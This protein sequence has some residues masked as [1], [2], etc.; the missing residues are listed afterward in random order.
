RAPAALLAEPVRVA[1]AA[2]GAY[3]WTLA[4]PY[5]VR[6]LWSYSG[7]SV[8]PGAMAPI[9][10]RTGWLVLAVAAATAVRVALSRLATH[11]GRL[12]G[13]DLPVPQPRDER[14][15]FA[16]RL[17][18]VPLAALGL[19]LLL[20][21]LLSHVWQGF[22]AWLVVDT[23]LFARLLLVP[24][25]PRYPGLVRRVPLLVRT[26]VAA[27]AVYAG[28]LAASGL[29]GS[30]LGGSGSGAARPVVAVLTGLVAAVLLLPAGPPNRPPPT[31]PPDT[32]PPPVTAPPVTAPPVTQD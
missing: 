25:I 4:A 11:Q 17:V 14:L 32:A 15:R 8:D 10:Q 19:V 13:A 21:G 6:P 1:S 29:A 23:L 30:G 20:S 9:E 16:L 26:I 3:G 18:G 5:L 7:R 28:W 31:L 24:M 2:L 27:L 12:A 22:F